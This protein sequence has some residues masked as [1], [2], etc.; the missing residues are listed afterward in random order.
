MR[1]DLKCS[2]DLVTLWLGLRLLAPFCT[3]AGSSTLDVAVRSYE[4]MIR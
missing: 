1:G 3:E 4:L 2:L